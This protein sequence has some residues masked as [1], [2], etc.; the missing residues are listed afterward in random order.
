MFWCLSSF[1]ACTSL[2]LPSTSGCSQQ[3]SFPWSGDPFQWRA[4]LTE[5]HFYSCW[6]DDWFVLCPSHTMYPN[7]GMT[8][9]TSRASLYSFVCVCV[10]VLISLVTQVVSS[11]L[12][13]ILHLI[14]STSLIPLFH[15]HRVF[16]FPLSLLHNA[17]DRTG[18][19]KA[20]SPLHVLGP[21]SLKNRSGSSG[22]I[23]VSVVFF[24]LSRTIL[25]V[26]P[27]RMFRMCGFF[28]SITTMFP[29]GQRSAMIWEAR[30]H[31][32]FL[33]LH[34]FEFL[35]WCWT[36][37][38]FRPNLRFVH[39]LLSLF[40]FP[41]EFDTW[42]HVFKHD[43]LRCFSVHRYS[44][45]FPPILHFGILPWILIFGHSPHS[46]SMSDSFVSSVCFVYWSLP[47]PVHVNMFPLWLMLEVLHRCLLSHLSIRS[48]PD[49]SSV[50]FCPSFRLH[51]AIRPAH[52]QVQHVLLPLFPPFSCPLPPFL[53]LHSC[54][55]FFPPRFA[56][57]LL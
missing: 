43:L 55:K 46:T 1:I 5:S 36:A 45:L 25:I 15:Y 17:D 49:L 30:K 34:I 32:Q 52:P 21:R 22:R 28:P 41:L 11:I 26:V 50:I 39:H 38:S 57:L 27:S 2:I 47:V 12:Y 4:F 37:W 51:A 31:S 13:H 44:D 16:C 53:P 6:R 8:H 40:F 9:M 7:L 20:V 29:F 19:S 56:S 48:Q 3:N 35:L 10:P 33:V 18:L 54:Q 24:S 23:H 42:K 14:S